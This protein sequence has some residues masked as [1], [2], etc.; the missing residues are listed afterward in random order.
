MDILHKMKEN[1]GQERVKKGPSIL[2]GEKLE[3]FSLLFLEKLQ[4]FQFWPYFSTRPSLKS[5]FPTYTK[6]IFWNKQ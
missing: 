1:L 4:F 5:D 3:H 6:I 2:P